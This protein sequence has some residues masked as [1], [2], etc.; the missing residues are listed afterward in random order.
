MAFL[1]GYRTYLIGA[2]LVVL[3]GLNAIGFDISQ[4]LLWALAGL[5]GITLRA[6]VK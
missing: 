3:A 5:G 1:K 2:V 4:D 6:A